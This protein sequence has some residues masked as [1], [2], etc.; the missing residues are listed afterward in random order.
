MKF[1]KSEESNLK[2]FKRTDGSI[3]KYNSNTKEFVAISKEGKIITYYKSSMRYFIHE[4][5]KNGVERVK[6]DW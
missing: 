6:G 5:N 1:A 3:C 2:V 4:W